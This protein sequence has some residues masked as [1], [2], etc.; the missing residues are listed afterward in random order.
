MLKVSLWTKFGKFNLSE[1]KSII[2]KA[3]IGS[4]GAWEGVKD[5]GTLR[6]PSL[7]SVT[8]IGQGGLTEH[9][10]FIHS[11]FHS[12]SCPGKLTSFE[13]FAKGD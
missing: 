4:G 6:E 7:N 3:N 8:P 10:G 12:T 2:L 13:K 1:D 9:H 5:K 11:G